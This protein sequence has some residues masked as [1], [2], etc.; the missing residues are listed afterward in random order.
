[1]DARPGDPRRMDREGVARALHALVEETRDEV[2]GRL[3]QRGD[4]IVA[5]SAPALEALQAVLDDVEAGTLPDERDVRIARRQLDDL[6]DHLCRLP[7]TLEEV[8]AAD[9]FDR[10]R[11]LAVDVRSSG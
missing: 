1:M 7:T 10:L 11:S 8:A 9:A 2:A 4:D 5:R 3:R 6:Q